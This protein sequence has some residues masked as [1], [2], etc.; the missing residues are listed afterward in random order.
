MRLNIHTHIY[1]IHLYLYINVN[2]GRGKKLAR[3][4]FIGFCSSAVSDTCSNSIRVMKTTKQTST[5]AISYPQA[6]RMVMEKDGSKY[7]DAYIHTL[8]IYVC[9][10][11]CYVYVVMCMSLCYVCVFCM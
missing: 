8:Y 2:I 9:G 10:C 5:V 1:N 4:A 6:F 3:N 11:V 7:I